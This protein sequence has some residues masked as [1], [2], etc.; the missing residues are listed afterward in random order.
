MRLG[1]WLAL[2]AI[3]LFLLSACGAPAAA[4][5]TTQ[6]ATDASSPTEAAAGSS[7]VRIGWGGSPDSLNPGVA[8]LAEAFTLSRL[9]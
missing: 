3:S 4:P 8:V 7:T 1:K 6:P 5:S 2:V 9:V